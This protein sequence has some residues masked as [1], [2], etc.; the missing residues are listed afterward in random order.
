MGALLDSDLFKYS[1]PETSEE[2]YKKWSSIGFLYG[3][4]KEN[5]IELVEFYE[6]AAK[7]LIKS[8]TK[9]YDIE[10]ITFP[11]IRR[12]Y[13]MCRALSEDEPLYNRLFEKVELQDKMVSLIDIESI[14]SKLS[15]FEK[16]IMIPG[17]EFI[18]NLDSQ[19]ELL[20][21]FCNN[22]VHGMYKSITS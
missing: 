1:E 22:E 4:K 12:I 13:A 21:L 15:K 7:L 11:A 6:K 10:M 2:I 9:Q 19:A 17:S 16:C 20:V 8:M 18:G 14:V 3:L 5:G